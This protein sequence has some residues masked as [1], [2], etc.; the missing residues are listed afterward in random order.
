MVKGPHTA[1]KSGL[2]SPQLGK[3][4]AQKRRPNTDKNKYINKIKILK[5]NVWN[6]YV[7]CDSNFVNIYEILPPP[8]K[9]ERIV[10]KIE[11]TVISENYNYKLFL[12]YF[13]TSPYP[14]NFKKKKEF[15]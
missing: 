8:E 3:A 1:M 10:T 7:C 13:L 15:F 9:I 11:R 4:L 2:H 14:L 5:K 12:F 6:S